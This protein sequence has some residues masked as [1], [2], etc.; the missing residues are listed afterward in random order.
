MYSLPVMSHRECLKFWLPPFRQKLER[1]SRLQKGET[2]MIKGL[3]SKP[4]EERLRELDIF[5]LDKSAAYRLKKQ[6]WRITLK[7][8]C[9]C[10]KPSTC[11]E[12]TAH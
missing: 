6:R 9:P 3:E 4:Y 12:E 5:S 7:P 8:M 1:L 10:A 2:K 11:A